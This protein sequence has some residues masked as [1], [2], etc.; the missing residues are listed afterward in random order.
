MQSLNDAELRQLAEIAARSVHLAVTEGLSLVPRLDDSPRAFREPA[1]VFVTLRRAG[2]LRGCI[3]TL[4]ANEPLVLAV[5]DRARA[6]AQH[7]PR[8]DPVA[9]LELDDLMVSV[10]VL[11]AP[12]PIEVS[13]YDDLAA[14]LRPG[15][16]GV[17]VEAGRHRA[18]F[19]P[20]VWDD[21]PD[22][23]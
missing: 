19:L 9:A 4:E 7:D 13:G 1:A 20:A 2:Q 11:T 15:V 3:G 10:S 22:P 14:R 6:A 21:L 17:V 23:R 16:D 18:T 8:F 5:A 12:V